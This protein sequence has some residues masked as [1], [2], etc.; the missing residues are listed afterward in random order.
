[1]GLDHRKQSNESFKNVDTK[2]K[3]RHQY[4]KLKVMTNKNSSS[5]EVSNL[6][7]RQTSQSGINTVLMR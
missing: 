7:K 5:K 4:K 6:V 1:M 3:D 2:I